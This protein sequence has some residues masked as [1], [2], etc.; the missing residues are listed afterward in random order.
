[1]TLDLQLPTSVN[2]FVNPN[3]V[4]GPEFMMQWNAIGNGDERHA[5]EVVDVNPKWMEMSNVERL[6]TTARHHRWLLRHDVLQG[7]RMAVIPAQDLQ[8]VNPANTVM[9]NGTLTTAQQAFSCQLVVEFN[10]LSAKLRVSCR[11][12]HP[13]LTKATLQLF[14]TQVTGVMSS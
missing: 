6:C 12:D 4:S 9:A 13:S 10:R 8:G 14:T 7:L 5:M 1:V 3:P 11:S 2:K